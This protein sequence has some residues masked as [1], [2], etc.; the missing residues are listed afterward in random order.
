MK[1]RDHLWSVLLALGLT[2][3]AMGCRSESGSAS[4]GLFGSRETVGPAGPNRFVT[5][6]NQI[7]T[8]AGLQVELPGLRPQAMALSPDGR[9]L[10]V[11]GKTS[12]LLLIDPISGAL[13][14]RV[15]LPSEK[16]AD[17]EP[18]P[19]SE[20]ILDPDKDGQVSY[21][22]LIFS[23]DGRRIFLS[24]VN[25]SVKVFEV[26]P[27]HR[28]SG[29]FTI[30]LPP[31]H[32]L[33]RKADIPSGLALSPDGRRLYVVLNL[34]NQLAELDALNGNLLHRWNVGVAPYDV[35]LVGAK[36]YVSNWGGRRPGAN[37]V[38]GPAGRG[39][40]VRV[41]DVRFIAKEGS[42]SVIDLL[43]GR[44]GVEILTGLH[45]SAMALS[46]NSRH[47]VVA[48]AASDTLSV[49]D[50]RTDK[51]VETIWTRQTP[52][53][54]FGAAPNALAFDASGRTLYVCN[55]SQNAVA[56][57]RF[58][59]GESKLT[60]LIPVGWYPGAV[61][62]DASRSAVYVANIKGIGSTRKVPPGE[63]PKFK[64]GQYFGTLSLVPIPSKRQLAALTRVALRNFRHAA[65]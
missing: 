38:T 3:A 29:L 43:S 46:P 55:G 28:V 6:A 8:P 30:P 2:F 20:N 26:D 16:E 14:Q 18:D 54:L 10:A 37:D 64:S 7:L 47:L 17:P 31:A 23:P 52:A 11:S 22:G 51:V 58:D 36:A 50:T 32:A 25:G 15:A 48:N 13:L 45:A 21:T 63:K 12:E 39:T 61:V 53:D 41:D 1:L 9:L 40:S 56:V 62:N 59:P 19:V 34:T 24:N 57:V 33:G 4:S 35:V 49:I 27:Q 5:P 44:V 65:V 42:V 60:G